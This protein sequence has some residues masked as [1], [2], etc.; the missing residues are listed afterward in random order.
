MRKPLLICAFNKFIERSLF[1]QLNIIFPEV[2]YAHNYH[3]R[4]LVHLFL[5]VFIVAKGA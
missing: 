3:R 2:E 5:S 4:G 1:L